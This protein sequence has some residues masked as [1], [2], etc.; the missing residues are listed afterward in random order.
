MTVGIL[1][2]GDNHLILAG[3]L[4]APACARRLA[5]SFGLSVVALG[6]VRSS[7]PWE[8]RTKEYRENLAWAVQL[9]S[10]GAPSSAVAA[11][12]NE[13]AARGITIYRETDSWEGVP[14]A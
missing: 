3:P 4:P 8:I 11:L 5:R 9:E 12:L 2:H 6:A 1:V 14:C 10:G 7:G 13:L